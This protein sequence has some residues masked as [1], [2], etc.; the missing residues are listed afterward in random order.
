MPRTQLK[1][2]GAEIFMFNGVGVLVKAF[3]GWT[4]L[5]RQNYITFFGIFK[6]FAAGL[7]TPKFRD[8]PQTQLK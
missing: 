7:R 1:K 2:S 6:Y 4:I 5:L 8:I 3:Q